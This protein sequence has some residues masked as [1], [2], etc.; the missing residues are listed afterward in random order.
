MRYVACII[1][2]V[3]FNLA[4]VSVL[5]QKN[6]TLK[7]VTTDQPIQIIEELAD[8][9]AGT[10]PDSLSLK[11]ALK[12]WILDLHEQAHLE[13]AVDTLAR[14]GEKEYHGNEIIRLG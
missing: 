2:I 1:I 3:C 9:V 12:K 10:Y 13:A 14:I 6:Y 7:I 5:A 11:T 4:T 8:K